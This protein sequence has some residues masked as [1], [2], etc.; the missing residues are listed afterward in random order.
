[1]IIENGKKHSSQMFNLVMSTTI[2]RSS[3]EV[4]AI[5]DRHQERTRADKFPELYGGEN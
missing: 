5:G 3:K 1:M 2:E 4:R